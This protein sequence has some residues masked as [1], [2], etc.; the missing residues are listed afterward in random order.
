LDQLKI[1]KNICLDTHIINTKYSMHP[2]QIIT[3]TTLVEDLDKHIYTDVKIN[4][5]DDTTSIIIDYH[6]NILSSIPFFD[7]LFKFKKLDYYDVIVP[8]VEGAID[9]IKSFY[10]IIYQKDKWSND[11][12]FINCLNYFGM[13]IDRSMLHFITVEPEEF[14]FFLIMV[15][16]LFQSWENVVADE[17]M[18]LS[19]RYNLPKDYNFSKLSA[20]LLSEL[21]KSQHLIIGCRC[22]NSIVFVNT[23]TK[24]EIKSYIQGY[25]ESITISMNDRLL[26]LYSNNLCYIIDCFNFK[27][28]TLNVDID[29]LMKISFHPNNNYIACYGCSKE[30]LLVGIDCYEIST[31]KK[32]WCIPFDNELNM[33]RYSPDGN[34]LICITYHH[35]FVIDANTGK[36][37]YN[38]HA[39]STRNQ[40][41]ASPNSTMLLIYYYP[42]IGDKNSS[43]K[44]LKMDSGELIKQIN[45]GDSNQYVIFSPD[46][47]SIITISDNEI[48]S[49]N[50]ETEEILYHIKKPLMFDGTSVNFDTKY[51]KFLSD[52]NTLIILS[53]KANSYSYTVDIASKTIKQEYD[54][55]LNGHCELVGYCE[56]NYVN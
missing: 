46:N 5:I 38:I 40:V 41:F 23:S 39:E 53:S 2:N 49:I 45:L 33:I 26:G 36:L 34:Y 32:I 25:A 56:L 14:D 10:G 18:M 15:E 9:I 22:R 48:I 30:T 37:M 44:I 16:N 35:I 55:Q 19:I 13:K 28:T 7:K 21:I 50:I 4:L 3:L 31:K 12:N 24:K 43:A 17:Q 42:I 52:N 27:M 1:E 20:I 51:A 54:H 8:S 47:S 29:Y 6:R 11:L